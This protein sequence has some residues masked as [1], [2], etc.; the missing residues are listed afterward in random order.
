MYLFMQID[1]HS[2]KVFL[3]IEVE[4]FVASA[5]FLGMEADLELLTGVPFTVTDLEII[6][7][8]CRYM[9]V[10]SSI[11]YQWE[12]MFTDLTIENV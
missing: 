11:F 10:K 9:F 4:K 7:K 2:H 3:F 1:R 6:W 12:A 5:E 8:I